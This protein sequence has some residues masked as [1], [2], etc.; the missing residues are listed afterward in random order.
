[1]IRVKANQL[2]KL[3]RSPSTTKSKFRQAFG[4]EKRPHI[5]HRRPNDSDVG[6]WCQEKDPQVLWMSRVPSHWQISYMYNKYLPCITLQ[7][8]LQSEFPTGIHKNPGPSAL[9]RPAGGSPEAVVGAI[10]ETARVVE[11]VLSWCWV[12]VE[13]VLSWVLS[14]LAVLSWC[15]VCV[16][17]VLSWCWIGVE[18]VLSWCWGGSHQGPNS[19]LNNSKMG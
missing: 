10:V 14:W 6:W 18:V 17:L 16:E 13:L 5:R 1:M 7:I 4:K 15:W 12:G 19:C 9:T 11:L 3:S 2:N 8:D